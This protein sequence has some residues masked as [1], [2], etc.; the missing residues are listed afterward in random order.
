MVYG[1]ALEPELVASWGD[2]ANYRYF[3]DKFGLGQ[4]RMMVEF[5]KLKNWRRQVLHAATGVGGQELQKVTAMIGILTEQMIPRIPTAEYDGA[6]SWLENAEQEHAG[7]PFHAIV[8]KENYRRH[9]A[10]ICGA[11]LGEQPDSRWD[12]ERN[13]VVNRNAADM[14]DAVRP[15]L[16]HC[17]TIIFIDPHFGPENSRHRRPLEAFLSVIQANRGYPIYTVEVLTATNASFDFFR[18]AC[19]QKMPRIIPTGLTVN[20]VKLAQQPNGEQLHNRYILTDIGGVTFNVGLDDG[21]IG[22]TDDVTLMD[23][24]QYE[25]RWSQY[26]GTSPA[27]VRVGIVTVRGP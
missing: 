9:E 6:R 8:A 22:Q 18:D 1:Y 17:S 27:F 21:D 20:F 2:K 26:S 24:K 4:P 7:K 3:Y 14:A 23:R 16:Q 19:E 13:R 11:V 15:L 12:I 10:V 25:L 5:P